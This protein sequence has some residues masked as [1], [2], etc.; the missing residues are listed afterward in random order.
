MIKHIV[1]WRLKEFAN[2]V[3]KEENARKLKSHL[4]SLKSKIKEIKRIEVGINIKSSDTAS[5][6]VLYSEFD[7]MDDLEA[8]QRHPEH[9]KVVDF[10]N[11]IRL[12]RRVVDYK[13]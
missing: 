13:V 4:E 9:M 3:N 2:G 8:Y 12:E 10:V 7:S 1:M 11:E 6:V 5:D